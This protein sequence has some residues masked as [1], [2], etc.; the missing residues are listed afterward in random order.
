MM[1]LNMGMGKAKEI[2]KK[3]L[4]IPSFSY[5]DPPECTGILLSKPN[6]DIEDGF[7]R[8]YTEL[9]IDPADY[10]CDSSKFGSEAA[11][12]LKEEDNF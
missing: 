9:E 5:P 7:I 1:A 11:K 8:L 12:I 2:F 6:F 4:P 10:P 3:P